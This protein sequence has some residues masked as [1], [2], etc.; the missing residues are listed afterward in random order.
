MRKLL[1][2]V[3]LLVGCSRGM[4]EEEA[5]AYYT[6]TQGVCH[7]GHMG[8]SLGVVV[9]STGTL[10]ATKWHCTADSTL[11]YLRPGRSYRILK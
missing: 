8:D 7:F 6:D 1:L 5:I 4:T 11:F 2:V 10:L 3:I 9:D